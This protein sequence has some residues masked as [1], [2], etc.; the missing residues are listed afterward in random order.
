MRPTPEPAVA[1]LPVRWRP[2]ALPLEP[3][4]VAGVGPVALALGHRASRA[5]DAMLA[6]WT[7]VAGPD[8]LVLLGT[9]ASLPWVDGAVYLGRDP[10]APALLL[11]CALE[12]D[13][14]PSL[15][16]RALL[17]GQGD[18]PLA[19]LPGSGVLVSVAAAKP[20]ARASLTAWLSVPAVEAAS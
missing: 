19:V 12:P 9:A 11:P 5:E 16:E 18:A 3:V 20:V 15:L 14:A 2:R 8:V 13:V 10:L 17:A 6:A 4:A 1:G 7:G